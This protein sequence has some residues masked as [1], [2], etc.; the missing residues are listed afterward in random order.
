MKMIWFGIVLA[1]LLCLAI[2]LILQ[3]G[4]HEFPHIENC[5][6]F[7]DLLL[8]LTFLTN[9]KQIYDHQTSLHYHPDVFQ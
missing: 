1:T 8:N 5:I 7:L 3:I 2:A 9:S 4:R 6:Y